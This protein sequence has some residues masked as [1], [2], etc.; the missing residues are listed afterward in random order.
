MDQYYTYILF[1]EKLNKFYVG[2]T[3]DLQRRLSEHNRGKTSFTKTGIP[4]QLKYYEVF[5]SRSEA[6]GRELEVKKR[7]DRKYIESLISQTG[8]EHPG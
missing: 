4:W 1:S 3:N 5:Q 6:I 7:K 8:S 2:S